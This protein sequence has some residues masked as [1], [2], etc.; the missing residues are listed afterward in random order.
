M[1]WNG[2]PDSPKTETLFTPNTFDHPSSSLQSLPI[3]PSP[4][5]ISEVLNFFDSTWAGDN[6]K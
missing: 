4:Y 6:K 2:G 3:S 5:P 1:A